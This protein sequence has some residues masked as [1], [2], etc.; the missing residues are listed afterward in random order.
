MTSDKHWDPKVMDNIISN[1]ADWYDAISDIAHGIINSPFDEFGE[2]KYLE[3]LP[4]NTIQRNELEMQYRNILNVN[5]SVIDESII[6]NQHDIKRLDLKV[7]PKIK[8]KRADYEALQPYFLN[9][10]TKIIKQ[11]ILNTT[12]YGR[13][14]VT[15]STITSTHKSPFPAANV[16][17]CN[18]AVATDTIYSTVPAVDTG[19]IKEAQIF[20]G[21]ESL[22]IDIYGMKND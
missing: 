9:A 16:I 11:T 1:K 15:G 4:N 6:T 17:R 18:K 10:P 14:P 21:R 7:S 12:Q 5:E 2:Y 8:P 20:V 3:P 13:A 22:M 19:G